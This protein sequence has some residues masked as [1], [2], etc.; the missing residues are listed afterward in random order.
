[1]K[2]LI[3]GA[4]GFIGKKLIASIKN[5]KIVAINHK[6]NQK[7]DSSIVVENISIT[8]KKIIK[9]IEKHNPDII[10]HLASLT[11]VA[12][13][14]K[15]H[16]K[17]FDTNV[18][19]TFNVIQGCLKT[20]TKLIFLSSREVYGESNY[21]KTENSRLSPKNIYGFTKL[22]AEQII[23]SHGKMGLDYVIL[24]PTQVYSSDATDGIINL[25]KSA[26]KKNKVIIFGGGQHVN[27]LHVDDLVR[28]II[29]IVNNWPKSKIFNVGIKETCTIEE[30]VKIISKILKKEIVI[31]YKKERKYDTQKFIP[32]I[33][34][35][36]SELKVEPRYNTQKG[37]KKII[38]EFS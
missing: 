18:Y 22:C 1:M 15:N 14:E 32:D 28:I 6:N 36:Q 11:G 13:C 34:K 23:S 20:K 7:F 27:L 29:N 16:K 3:T 37:L 17:A 38:Q 24:R 4:S 12:K 31:E 10:I 8:D 9:K 21:K 2:I 30:V 25:I 35:I 5:S 33:T 26:V 19:G